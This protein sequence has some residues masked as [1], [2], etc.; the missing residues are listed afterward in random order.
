MADIEEVER[1]YTGSFLGAPQPDSRDLNIR[2]EYRR[3]RDI[4]CAGFPQ[5]KYYDDDALFAGNL[6]A[7]GG[8]SVRG[9]QFMAHVEIARPI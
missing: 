7:R 3:A 2:L 4:G 9:V 6:I 1:S 5:C 8:G